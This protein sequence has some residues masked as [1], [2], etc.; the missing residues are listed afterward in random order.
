MATM[1][2][3]FWTTNVAHKRIEATWALNS[4]LMQNMLAFSLC[5]SPRVYGEYV[6]FNLPFAAFFPVHFKNNMQIHFLPI[7]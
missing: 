5:L 3:T 2:R 4:F 1:Y 7:Y 6:S